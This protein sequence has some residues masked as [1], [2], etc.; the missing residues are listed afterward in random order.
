MTAI[1]TSSLS[2]AFAILAPTSGLALSSS[3]RNKARSDPD[4]SRMDLIFL[5]HDLRPQ[6]HN[7]LSPVVC[8]YTTL[9]LQSNRL[10]WYTSRVE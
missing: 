3:L 4:R 9:L 2:E 5:P 1:L 10:A 8:I 7:E 6:F